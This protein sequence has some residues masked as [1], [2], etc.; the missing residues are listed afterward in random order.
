M[1]HGGAGGGGQQIAHTG[2]LARDPDEIARVEA[3]VGAVE[4]GVL[5]V[6]ALNL[7]CA[8]I[9]AI[10]VGHRRGLIPADLVGVDAA[11]RYDDRLLDGAGAV[12]IERGGGGALDKIKRVHKRHRFLR[13]ALHQRVIRV[14]GELGGVAGVGIAGVL[15]HILQRAAE[16]GRHLLTVQGGVGGEGGRRGAGGNARGI[17]LEDVGVVRVGEGVRGGGRDALAGQRFRQTHRNGAELQTADGLG[18]VAA[19]QGSIEQIVV[20][21]EVHIAFSPG[22][23][24]GG[25][26]LREREG[27]GIQLGGVQRLRFL[28]LQG[29]VC[30]RLILREGHSRAGGVNIP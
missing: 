7:P 9:I 14:G 29:G 28:P 21:R 23:G 27:A 8:A 3:G 26:L 16:E 20:E 11:L 25:G 30:F 17:G 4:G 13:P 18:V 12:G 10:D 2:Q 19:E 5:P 15:L 1:V 6:L 22:A 24:L